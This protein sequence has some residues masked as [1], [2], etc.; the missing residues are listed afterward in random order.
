MPD[1]I[2]DLILRRKAAK[3]KLNNQSSQTVTMMSPAISDD[4]SSQ[5]K[6][7]L[8]DIDRKISML[9]YNPNDAE[10]K[11]GDLPD[12]TP[13][14]L[15]HDL[16]N[17]E[18][19][20]DLIRKK[21]AIKW[22][23][24]LVKSV[25]SILD[26]ALRS[27]AMEEFDYI[28]KGIT[29]AKGEKSNYYQ[30][31]ISST[32][33]AVDIINKY[34]GSGDKDEMLENLRINSEYGLA[35]SLMQ[36]PSAQ[37]RWAD[38]GLNPI[39]GIAL[40]IKELFSPEGKGYKEQVVKKAVLPEAISEQN[41]KKAQL[42]REGISILGKEIDYLLE[43]KSGAVKKA[44]EF[45]K[46]NEGKLAEL[47]ELIKKDSK[48]SEEMKQNLT[49]FHTEYKQAIEGKDGDVF[50]S[51]YNFDVL[52]AK[53]EDKTANAS[54]VREY[55]NR[56]GKLN[57][58]VSKYKGDFDAAKENNVEQN[59]AVRE[60][61]KIVNKIQ[62]SYQSVKDTGKLSAWA[63][64]LAKQKGTLGERYPEYK[65]QELEGLVKDI[66]G[67]NVGLG[68]KTV[69]RYANSI[70]AETVDAIR[71][72]WNNLTIWD[73]DKL[74]DVEM[75]DAYRRRIED[76]IMGYETGTQMV[77]DER[78]VIPVV[79]K[80][81]QDELNKIKNSNLS[82]EEKYQQNYKIVSKA[83]DD[84]KVQYVANPKYGKYNITADSVLN[85]VSSMSAQFVG[86]MVQT[87]LGG[88]FGNVSKARRLLTRGSTVFGQVFGREYDLAVQRGDSNP[89]EQASTKAGIEMLSEFVFDDVEFVKKMSPAFAR[90]AGDM[91]QA[92]WKM[93]TSGK[94]KSNIGREIASSLEALFKE[95]TV[96]E[97][98]AQ[99][100]GNF[101]DKYMFGK[102]ND[103]TEGLDVAVLAGT[104]GFAPMALIG[105]PLKYRS[106][107]MSDK[108]MMYQAGY[109]AD[110][111]IE[112]LN[113]QVGYG[114]ITA[115]EAKQRIEAVKTM[116][117]V[118]GGMS[119]YDAN[120][121]PLTDNQKA[122]YAWNEYTKIKAKNIENLPEQQ[123]Q[124]VE[125]V[126]AEADQSSSNILNGT[127]NAT[128]ESTRPMQG[129][130]A[131]GGSVQPQA[132]VEGQQAEGQA[133]QPTA[134]VGYSDGS[135]QEV[136]I[137]EV[138]QGLTA[139]ATKV[140]GDAINTAKSLVKTGI[141]VRVFQNQQDFERES[142]KLGQQ[143]RGQ[144]VF[145]SDGKQVLI[146]LS[147]INE[148]KD[149]GIVWHE[150]AHP[151]MNILRNTNTPLYD[152]MAKGFTA[153]AK[154]GGVFAQVAKW[155]KGDYNSAASD[156]Q[157]D[158][159][160]VETISLI[161]DG[162]IKLADI[163][164]SF[165]QQVIDFVNQVADFLGLGQMAD[166]SE[167]VFVQ[168][169]VQIAGAL[170]SGENIE[171]VVGADNVMRTENPFVGQEKKGAVQDTTPKP[172]DFKAAEVEVN[173][174]IEQQ[175]G[176]PE[177]VLIIPQR[178]KDG[179]LKIS[180]E[181]DEDGKRSVEIKYKQA[182]YDLKK[183]ALQ[184]IDKDEEKAA[185]KLSDQIVTDYKAS[186]DRPEIS[187]G[188]GWY[189]KMRDRFQNYF[190]A[191]IETFGQL[192]AATS[193][194]TGVFDNFKQSVE[195]FR[196]FSQGKYN[197]LL[198]D[199]D[200][201]V[202]DIQ[203]KS[204][205]QLFQEWTE[206]N[207]TKRPREFKAS[208][209]RTKRVNRYD[210]FPL[211]ENG[212]KYN[213]NSKK[214]LQA[215]YG[216]WLQQTEGPK[217][218]NFAGNLTGRS[219]G[220]TID[221]WAARY[222]RRMIFQGNLDRW[223]IPPSL[224]KGV[225][226]SILVSGE[227]SGDYPFAEKVMQKAADKLGINADDLQAF[228]WYLEKDVWDKNGWTNKAG[229]EKASF[230]QGADMLDT[231]RYQAGVT[232]YKDAATF[233]P[234]KYQEERIALQNEIGSLPGVIAARITESVGEFYS[235]K[236]GIYVE[237]TFDVEFTMQKGADVTPVRERV[238]KILKDYKQD[239][240]LFSKFVPEDHP[241][242]RPII[243][244]GLAEPAE[245]SQIID[246]VKE[247]LVKDDV[248]GFTIAK[249]AR[250]RILGVRT[251][252]VPE[253]EDVSVEE[254][255]KRFVN[256][257][258]K[259]KD[260]YGKNRDISYLATG[261]VDT[262]VKF[263]ED[264]KETQQ[265][266][267]ASDAV[268]GIP[269]QLQRP[270]GGQISDGQSEPDN[271]G[272][273]GATG[274]MGE[275]SDPGQ[276][277]RSAF[278]EV[279][280]GFYSPIENRINEFKQNN[281]SAQKWKEIVG[282][283][284]DEAVFSGLSEWLS[285]QSPSKQISKQ[286]VS[287]FIKD[288]RIEI[289]EAVKG[290][291]KFSFSDDKLKEM[292]NLIRGNDLLGF[293]TI[294]ETREAIRD[295]A[296]F[297]RNFDI[298]DQRLITLGNEYR[299]SVKDFR[300]DATK[301]SQYQLPGGE[302]YKEVLITLPSEVSKLRE[303]F[304]QKYPNWGAKPFEEVFSKEDAA[305]FQNALGK[306]EF[307][308]SHFD[309]SNIITHLRMNT[310]TD[311][312]GK[313]V[314]FLEEVQSDWG[315]KGKKEG[316]ANSDKEKR[317]NELLSKRPETT[318]REEL[319]IYNLQSESTDSKTPSAPYVTNTNAWV[320]LGLKVALKEA[321]K[322]GA[323]RI[324]WT[325]GDQQ[326]DRYDLSDKIDEIIYG[327]VGDG[328]YEVAGAKRGELV[329][330]DE[331]P[332]SKLPDILGK[333]L[334]EKVISNQGEK[335]YTNKQ[336]DGSDVVFYKL[337]TKDLKVGGKG[338]KAFYGDAKT[339]GIV[340]NVAKALVKELIGTEGKIVAST[341]GK[342]EQ[343]AI[344]ITPELEASV[345]DGMAQFKNSSVDILND[346][347]QN[348]MSAARI[349]SKAV[350]NITDAIT[351]LGYGHLPEDVREKLKKKQRLIDA[352]LNE[353]NVLSKRLAD[354]VKEAYGKS[355]KKLD[356]DTLTLLDSA[357][358]NFDGMNMREKA[359]QA[360]KIPDPVL[361]ILE[362][363]RDQV[364][365]MSLKLIDIGVLDDS[366]EPSFD[367]DKGLGV[368]LTRT[369]RKYDDPEW[370]NK[371][372]EPVRQRAIQYLKANNFVRQ[373]DAQ[374][375]EIDERELTDA[376]VEGLVNYIATNM[377]P[378]MEGLS[379]AN[380]GK[381]KVDILKGRKE[382][383][384]EIRDLM[385][386][387][388]DPMVNF[389][390]SM[391]KMSSLAQTHQ[392]LKAIAEE[393]M[394]TLFFERPT[395]THYAPVAGEDKNYLQP[396]SGL[397]TTPE[398][399]EA[400][401]KV[402]SSMQGDD[403]NQRFLRLLAG[404]NGIAKVGKT[405][406]SPASWV[407]NVIGG[408]IMMLKDGHIFGNGY[409]EGWKTAIGY[410]ANKSKDDPAF[411]AKIREY[412]EQG[413][414]GDGVQGGEFKA[415]IKAAQKHEDPIEWLQSDSMLGK[416]VNGVKGFYSA[417][418][419][420][421]RVYTYENE[422]SRLAKR[423]PNMTEEQLQAEASR[424]ARA[425]Y[426]TYSELPEIIRQ[427]AKFIPISSFP[428]FSAEL[429]RTTK[430]SIK[431]AFEEIGDPDMRDVGIKRLAGVISALGFG[432]TLA[433]L[434]AMLVG[435][436]DEEEKSIRR[437][438]PTWSKNSPVIWLGRDD[439]GMPKY[440][441]LGFS[442]PFSYFKKPVVA[443]TEDAPM[444]DRI[445]NAVGEVAAPFISPEIFFSALAK[446]TKK[447]KE[448]D[449][450][451]E[452]MGKYAGP[453]Y[454][455]LEPGLVASMRRIGKGLMGDVDRYGQQY[456]PSLELLA[457]FSG[458]RIKKMDVPV[459]F[460]F[461]S[462]DFANTKRDIMS[463]Y[464]T[465]KAKTV[466]DPEKQAEELADSN[467]KLEK[468]FNEYKKDYDAAMVLMTRNMTAKE[469]KK[470]LKN[471]MKDRNIPSDFIKAIERGTPYPTIEDDK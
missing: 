298:Q 48:L 425:T 109:K 17:I 433:G 289:K 165:R 47:G 347:I 457:F 431:I 66:A 237:P 428:A 284:S 265:N 42:E 405:A 135:G 282:A 408:H 41:F 79:Q 329:F 453:V 345:Q 373:F 280:D 126:A 81:I 387:Y 223:R 68:K 312:D 108:L 93:L 134:N 75:G 28:Y 31:A 111:V 21:A 98:L 427:L 413:I 70:G 50:I 12:N 388:K 227:M 250:G 61:N 112:E 131:E 192:L 442:D 45:Y 151:V 58:I 78:T 163:P 125:Q 176:Q 302:N 365:A 148:V 23:A 335:S 305:R 258:K 456:D 127:D 64:Y 143:A 205:E 136:D 362:Q 352:D 104:I 155:A 195:A 209:Y 215:L 320:K 141:K 272:G 130:P 376:E 336:D 247:M 190:G 57:Q 357:L 271:Q 316:F 1:P 414:L 334:A 53:V 181:Y 251:Q 7:D 401:G 236:D 432:S 246:D 351:N 470:I 170:R 103:I 44:D 390:K 422:K 193:A 318:T 315:Q 434:S 385:G 342:T 429:I 171:S 168:K 263:Q 379:S 115:E 417:Q 233:D 29:G 62:E 146:N 228:L 38:I 40:D 83:F 367:G 450:L 118:V 24:P 99:L 325:T 449:D 20:V 281:A 454:E 169:A 471:T 172:K 273:L 445:K 409:A 207:P 264:G 132:T 87:Y 218:K 222:M 371:V 96:E 56:V 419:D 308:S 260:K 10:Q 26:P 138:P 348:R 469:A 145:M 249:D 139:I 107:N 447:L 256:A 4:E 404:V 241:N 321:V 326:N 71:K 154:Q 311:A 444:G 410:F 219:F 331:I 147:K 182:P 324:A 261:S 244:I 185:E 295:D 212:K 292:N 204:D 188:I 430:N 226:Y 386:E 372:P 9:G 278:T 119:M 374:G 420:I 462:R 310:R 238:E 63:E 191:N 248:R 202:K 210:K 94:I 213:A 49:G 402:Q 16:L 101:A 459:G 463:G 458:Q 124:E 448:S 142:A 203:S 349:T 285:S 356:Q 440:V 438:F 65:Q 216:N 360:S 235:E 317:L 330:G 259:I 229:A 242:A 254:G 399:A 337:K 314:L 27:K 18:N 90:I 116:K 354:A 51:P 77:K 128:Y 350:K 157:T 378:V 243:E 34:N 389:A 468:Y 370:V 14:F 441:D 110:Q 290:D 69:F 406:L 384:E 267:G 355:Y 113:R 100:G 11:L 80:D 327:K 275:E 375:N 268:G 180:I 398:I 175:K 363:M 214:V 152:N 377:Q 343:P 137:A 361:S 366:L 353:M 359:A 303:E 32:K 397:Y 161:G 467:E 196:L 322:Q 291:E 200:K 122:Q 144:G 198:E 307:K 301:Y 266:D 231:E 164:T 279:V 369:Y 73:G 443:M 341:I 252:F 5:T 201:F 293:D 338:M 86:Q 120:G 59:S 186:K 418:D 412:I 162:K 97:G 211:K 421:F 283:K 177:A 255:I 149:W 269:E 74:R 455:A 15:V 299:N 156:V 319:E 340:A 286:E 368:Y 403:V 262:Q 328:M 394:G 452:V 344:D 60:Y 187:A 304:N 123:R 333:D 117:E 245:K 346:A 88:G 208:E 423:K 383:P 95:G 466:G 178:E 184:Y 234:V 339:P 461:K 392:T 179:K 159:A 22:Q 174:L 240:T 3:G 437:Y 287:Q 380:L 464:Y 54:E 133:T 114:A 8:F 36:D 297:A 391:A 166:T 55:N 105:L 37:Q 46:Q 2:L 306:K 415:I 102:D 67:D 121:K 230:E 381:T 288:N 436:G 253:F 43:S 224:E 309:E 220:P 465:E 395:G 221:V 13:D 39:Q 84:K 217:T 106:A 72:V 439:N 194:R 426:P 199:Y 189:S 460:S 276:P 173:E 140:I 85:T 300:Q 91:S 332:E 197:E 393:N 225:D 416:M 358:R 25:E 232:T 153:L 411:Q 6:L 19:P 270:E 92:E 239:A 76:V 435:V 424:K 183:G 296:D 274:R 129:M 313:K 446:G 82:E 167:R 396:L 364:D 33:A 323:D 30:N 150:G 294:A 382:I 52:K 277:R 407:R 400:F 158:E 451:D 160:M 35:Q 257:F 89:F 206:E